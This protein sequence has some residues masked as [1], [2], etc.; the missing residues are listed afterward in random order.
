M[1]NIILQVFGHT[2]AGYRAC[3]EYTVKTPPANND[4][5]RHLAPDF[6]CLI[7]YRVVSETNEYE[8]LRSGLFR[9]I[10]TFKTLRGW[11]NGM[12]NRRFAKIIN[13]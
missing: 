12:T 8:D 10:D 9:R 6:Q 5:A 11:H 4:E 1:T 13:S 2:W 7:D 3:Y